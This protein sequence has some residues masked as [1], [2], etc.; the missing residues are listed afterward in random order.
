MKDVVPALVVILAVA[1][2]AGVIFAIHLIGSAALTVLAFLLIGGLVLVGILAASS[3]PIRAWKKRDGVPIEKQ[4]IREVRILDSRPA[5]APQLPA[6]QQP[7][8]GVFPEL[9]RASFA[10]GRLAAPQ[11][12]TVDAEVRH[13]DGDDWAGDITA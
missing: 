3:L 4:V 2:V 12:E 7:P 1:L 6:P 11:G 13:L 10:A 5:P 8:F 9:L